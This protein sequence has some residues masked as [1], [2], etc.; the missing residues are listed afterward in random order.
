M[1]NGCNTLFDEC[2]SHLNTISRLVKNDYS[3]NA[4]TELSIFGFYS[5]FVGKKKTL[6]LIFKFLRKKGVSYY[7]WFKKTANFLKTSKE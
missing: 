6:F 7:N 3:S 5:H 1:K 4:E 2:Y